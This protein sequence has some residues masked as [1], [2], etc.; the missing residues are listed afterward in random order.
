MATSSTR[1]DSIDVRNRQGR[2]NSG[3]SYEPVSMIED[4]GRPAY[5]GGGQDALAAYEL[6]RERA[7]A[8]PIAFGMREG[9]RATGR[10]F[11]SGEGWRDMLT[12]RWKDMMEREMGA[13]RIRRTNELKRMEADRLV[14]EQLA[15]TRKRNLAAGL[16]LM[17]NANMLQFFR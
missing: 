1:S 12:F 6:N 5:V 9:F 16:A 13:E 14:E 2:A 17:Q 7:D 15:R 11:S 3:I 10:I 8:N 4:S